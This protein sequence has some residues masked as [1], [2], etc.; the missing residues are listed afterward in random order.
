MVLDDDKVHDDK[1]HGDMV[2]DDKVLHDKVL[3]DDKV[4]HDEVLDGDEVLDDEQGL[5]NDEPVVQS[6][7]SQVHGSPQKIQDQPW[8]VCWGASLTVPRMI[9]KNNLTSFLS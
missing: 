5:V 7:G 1:V 6:H 2:L 4:L 8:L 3:D 9:Y